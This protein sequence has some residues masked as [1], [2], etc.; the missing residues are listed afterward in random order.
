MEMCPF[1]SPV[2]AAN[3]VDGA[4][5]N[6]RQHWKVQEIAQSY[7]KWEEE[8]IEKAGKSAEVIHEE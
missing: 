4:S 1:Q 2:T 3:I 6:G 7:A 8:Q 5:L